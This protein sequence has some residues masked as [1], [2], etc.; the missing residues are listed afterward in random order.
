[1]RLSLL[2]VLCVSLGCAAGLSAQTVRGTV[3]DE[4]SQ[5]PIPE[6]QVTLV[7]SQGLRAGRVVANADGSFSFYVTRPD[8]Y[9]LRAERLGYRQVTS[10]FVTLVPG[11]SVVLELRMASRS[12][13]LAPLTVVAGGDVLRERVLAGFEYRRRRGFGRYVGPEEIEQLHPFYT[14][15]ILQHVPFVTVRGGFTRSVELSNRR[16]GHCTPTVFI[17]RNRYRIGP[18]FALDDMVAGTR[19]LAVEVYPTATALPAEFS[20]LDNYNCGVI[21]IWTRVT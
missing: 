3:L 13:V 21:A 9:Q 20:V 19:V 2:A 4:S 7:N 11:D 6:A 14:T 16:G 17:D 5:R 15:D 8:A 12:V 1:M 10:P 18:D